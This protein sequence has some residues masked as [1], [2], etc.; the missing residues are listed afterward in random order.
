MKKKKNSKLFWLILGGLFVVFVG[1]YISNQTGYY[2]SKL[3]NKTKITAEAI[4]KFEKDVAEGKDVT[5]DQYLEK[6]TVDYS[7]S[8]TKL[9]QNISS[10]VE[11]FMN[12]GIG[13]LFKVLSKLFS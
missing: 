10:G 1:L 9:G 8:A 4:N 2:E 6:Q 5:I 7:N 3:A 13:R 12:E 11:D